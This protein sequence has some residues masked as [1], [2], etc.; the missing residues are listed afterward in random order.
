[1]DCPQQVLAAIRLLEARGF[2]AYAVGG[3]VRDGLLGLAPHDWDICTAALTEEMKAVFSGF[4]LVETGIAHGTLTVNLDGLPLEIT[5]YRMDGPYSDHRRPDGV[6]FTSRLRDDL[7]RRDF[8]VN[9]M[10]WH[11]ERGLQDP[12]GGKSDLENRLLRAVGDPRKRFEEDALRLMRALRFAAAYDF[13]IEPETASA[14]REK[15]DLLRYVAAE[16]LRAELDRLLVSRGVE[17]ILT[18]YPDVLAVFLPFIT[19]MIGLEQ[20]SVYHHLDVWRHTAAS[21]AAAVPKRIVRL[22]LLLHDAGKPSCFSLDETGH[23]HFY[24][25]ASASTAIAEDTLRALKYDR[26]TRESVVRLVRYHDTPIPAESPAVKR[27]LGRLGE[28]E[29]RFLLD[30]KRGDAKGHAPSVVPASLAAVDALEGCLDQV[31]EAGACFSVRDLAVDGNDVI[32]CGIPKGPS[33]GKALAFLTG[34]VVE[35]R[36]PN[37]REVLLGFLRG[38]SEGSEKP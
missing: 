16:R 23:G 26:K 4:R 15:R 24:G 17:R 25:H 5:T 14:L 35:G 20:R 7:A 2:E 33:V 38:D 34:E 32:A 9:A 13:R 3:C 6:H 19:P 30:I 22:A 29:F 18:D 28:E 10:A 27:W 37:E 36:L 1:M 11:P 31:I 12:F 21:V 8:T